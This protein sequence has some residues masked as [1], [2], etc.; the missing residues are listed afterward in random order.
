[1]PGYFE[2]IGIPI[3]AGRDVDARN[4]ADGERV[5]VINELMARGIFGDEDPI[6]RQVAVDWGMEEPVVTR[7]IGVVGDVRMVRITSEPDWQMYYAY[8]QSAMTTM[9]LAVRT[10]GDPSL[11]TNAVRNILRAKD[12][13]I[14][15][16]GA[17]TMES[18]IADTVSQT[19]V[20]MLT[21]TLFAWVAA[22][23]AAI[24]LYSVLAY[25]VA[26]RVHE[27]GIRVAL[28]ATKGKVIQLV[29]HQGLALVGIGLVVGIGGAIGVT[30][31]IQQ[32]LYG[33]TPTDPLTFA[34]V[35]LLFALVGLM[36]CLVPGMR[37]A[38]QDPVRALQAE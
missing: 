24:G 27:I 21:L 34:V 31:L 7:V 10:A 13:D 22:F 32:Q 6:G 1:M 14:P 19:R 4:V 16:A 20:I 2:A 18:V 38:R 26:R 5:L 17:A 15:L 28:G 11:V 37:A 36:A 23:L 33:V 35:G 8:P 25:F 3:L 12:P 29:L 30:R 9:R